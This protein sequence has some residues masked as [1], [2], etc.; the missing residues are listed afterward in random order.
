[1]QS[2]SGVYKESYSRRSRTLGGATLH[3][4]QDFGWSCTL[5]EVARGAKS[6]PIRSHALGGVGFQ[7]ESDSWR[8]RTLERVMHKA[9][10]EPS[11]NDYRETHPE[12]AP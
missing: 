1:M 12:V 9:Q 11:R 3:E 6:D 8:S 7:A 2:E 5:G 10:P 4:E